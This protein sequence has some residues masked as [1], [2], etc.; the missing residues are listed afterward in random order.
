V[1]GCRRRR[2]RRCTW[3]MRRSIE[4]HVSAGEH[5]EEGPRAHFEEESS[6][7]HPPSLT[8]EEE[9]V[10]ASAVPFRGTRSGNLEATISWIQRRSRLVVMILRPAHPCDE[11]VQLGG[12]AGQGGPA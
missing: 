4:I 2:G 6:G 10:E 12:K 11:R 5:A 9:S 3:Q 7:Y 1:G 8:D